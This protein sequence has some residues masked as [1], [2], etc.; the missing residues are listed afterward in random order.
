M[1]RLLVALSLALLAACSTETER[2]E[3][4]GYTERWQPVGVA[5]YPVVLV[6]G[7]SYSTLMAFCRRPEE[8][9]TREEFEVE[10]LSGAW[11]IDSAGMRY[12]VGGV[13]MVKRLTNALERLLSP[14]KRPVAVSF[15]LQPAGM[16]ARG[17][18]WKLLSD[19]QDNFRMCGLRAGDGPAELMRGFSNP[20]CVYPPL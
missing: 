14:S 15:G 16:A 12:Q 19:Y 13:R 7:G 3:L 17:D 4:T 2:L 8:L 9:F 10:R 5:R 20:K 11:V 1:A 18:L 6:S